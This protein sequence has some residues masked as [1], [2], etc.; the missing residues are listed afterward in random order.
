MSSLKFSDYKRQIRRSFFLIYWDVGKSS[1]LMQ[2]VR[3]SSLLAP[4]ADDDV[5][6]Y[7]AGQLYLQLTR[8]GW[9]FWCTQRFGQW[10]MSVC[11]CICVN[12][13]DCVLFCTYT[14]MQV[15]A[16]SVESNMRLKF[17][18]EQM[19]SL[20]MVTCLLCLLFSFD[21]KHIP[22]RKEKGVCWRVM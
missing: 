8:M 9:Y 21:N 11:V 12:A 6:V 16:W 2:I 10:M 19:T 20:G 5:E 14:Y 17:L 1:L 4:Q 13:Q 18:T 3:V 7:Y 22:K 15:Y